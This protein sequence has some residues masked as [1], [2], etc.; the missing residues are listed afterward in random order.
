MARFCTKCGTRN[1]NQARFCEECGNPMPSA[2]ATPSASSIPATPVASPTPPR[3]RRRSLVLGGGIV[4]VLVACG[5]GLA[6]WL[7][8]ESASEASFARAIDTHFSGNAHAREKILCTGNLP[9]DKNPIRVDEYDR[10]TRQYMDMLAQAGVYEAPR[11]ESSGGYV[12]RT[13][14]VYALSA[15][16]GKWVRGNRLCLGEGLQ[17]K[18]VSGFEQLQEIQGVPFAV[19]RAELVITG[20]A[21]WLAKAADR[22][23]L[24]RE[25]DRQSMPVTLSL[26]R[27]EGKWAVSDNAAAAML[28]RKAAVLANAS[29]KADTGGGF[30]DKLKS[31]FSFGGGH[32]LVGRW[33]DESGLVSMEFTRDSYIQNGVSVAAKFETRGDQVT[34]TP[35]IGFG[36]G[37]VLKM[38][39]NDTALLDMGLAS[40]TLKRVN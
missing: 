23:G 6:W 18:Q 37:L 1:E 10:S 8:P 26:A 31:L 36:V 9:Y 19:A 13:H 17:A 7:A 34:V 22:E 27:M 20:E 3:P 33:Q 24:L 39:D 14:Y 28:A 11:V 32:P 4:A 2:A 35:D 12:P 40:V 16:G 29:G 21:P 30:F 15:E 25:L 38:R 5:G